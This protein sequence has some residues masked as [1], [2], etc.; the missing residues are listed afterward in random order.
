V[1]SVPSDKTDAVSVIE[2]ELGHALDIKGFYPLSATSTSHLGSFES[3][4]DKLIQFQNSVSL[5]TGPN[6]EAA[7]NGNPIPLT[8]YPLSDTR[9]SQNIYHLRMNPI[10][11][12]FGSDLMTGADF[13][14][15]FRYTISATDVAVVEDITGLTAAM[16]PPPPPQPPS[17]PPMG[18]PPDEGP[19]PLS[20]P[21]KVRM[22]FIHDDPHQKDQSEGSAD[23]TTVDES[24]RLRCEIYNAKLSRVCR[25]G[26][27][28]PTMDREVGNT[29]S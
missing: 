2:H 26:P 22:T 28:N 16:E 10:A 11:G 6:A 18:P 15:G 14:N 3:T 27:T 9:S 12:P 23:G 21:E 24:L 4:Y 1:K 7:N 8:H 20:P 19:T 5:F 17:E 25:P 29:P 13:Q